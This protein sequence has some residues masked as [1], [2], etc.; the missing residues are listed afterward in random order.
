MKFTATKLV[1]LTAAAMIAGA[2]QAP[3]AAAGPMQV[4]VDDVGWA[5]QESGSAV[6]TGVLKCDTPRSVDL[7]V[8]MTQDHG[9]AQA[10][11]SKQVDCSGT[12]R[13]TISLNPYGEFTQGIAGVDVTAT[14]TGQEPANASETIG[15][16]TCTIIGTLDSEKI[17][18]T[19]RRDIICG[20]AGDDTIYGEASN[21]IIRSYNGN[22]VVYGGDGDDKV[23]AG[24]GRDYVYG[25][26]GDDT[27][28]GD[29]HND[30]VNGGGG[31]DTCIG[32]TGADRFARCEDTNQAG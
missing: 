22:D 31:N 32:G 10:E 14:S 12:T 28:D 24:F 1:S 27:L 5:N 8:Q 18:G 20:L 2:C 11:N 25:Q 3:P 6:V 13:W 21:D 4:S 30:Y 15:I 17:H 29:E 9:N 23:L 7:D 19:P 16:K 26:T